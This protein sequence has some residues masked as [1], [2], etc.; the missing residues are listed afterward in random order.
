L[1]YGLLFEYYSFFLTGDNMS[2][3]EKR[4]QRETEII[5]KAISLLSARGFLDVRMSDIA[6]EAG[7][8]MGTIYSHFESKED[9]IVACAHLLSLDQ[10]ALFNAIALQPITA[11]EKIITLAQCSWLIATQHPDLIEIDN[12]SLM[13]SVWRRA[14]R[15]R[16]QSLNQLHVEL[17]ATF[18]NMVMAAI[19]HDIQGHDHLDAAQKE[20]LATYLTHGMWGLC[21]GLSSTAQSGYANNHCNAGHDETNAHFTTNY[22]NFLRGY[23]WQEEQPQ[24]VFERC[25]EIARDSMSHTQWYS[26]KKVKA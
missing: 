13:P 1:I 8:S 26:Q 21:V 5:E 4:E 2:R 19:E 23:G 22:S 14:T 16:A 15:Q 12:L 3:R 6:G 18:L 17:A 9:L 24:A 25:M 7:Y 10:Q 11:I 20:L